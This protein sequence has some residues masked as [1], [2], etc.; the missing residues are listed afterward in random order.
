MIQA[1]LFY[2]VDGRSY[3]LRDGIPPQK[4]TES[5]SSGE[6]PFSL[7]FHFVRSQNHECAVR[8]FLQILK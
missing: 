8:F 2:E 7:S 4:F 6:S 5:L 3:D 1:T